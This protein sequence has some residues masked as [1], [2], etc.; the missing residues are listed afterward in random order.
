MINNINRSYFLKE[1][2]YWELMKMIKI[3][4]SKIIIDKELTERYFNFVKNLVGNINNNIYNKIREWNIK[5]YIDNRDVDEIVN[6]SIIMKIMDKLN[7]KKSIM[8]DIKIKYIKREVKQ[9]D[10]EYNIFID[11]ICEI[12]KRFILLKEDI[13]YITR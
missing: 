13:K 8:G 7:Y 2:I 1:N 4:K 12:I 3:N 5:Y 6:R 10:N 9:I 11:K